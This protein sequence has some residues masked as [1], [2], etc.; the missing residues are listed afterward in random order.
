MQTHNLKFSKS[1]TCVYDCSRRDSQSSAGRQWINTC[2]IAPRNLFSW[3]K[4]YHHI[5]VY[6][7]R[8]ILVKHTGVYTCIHNVLF[9]V[10]CCLCNV[11]SEQAGGIFCSCF[12]HH[13]WV[14]TAVSVGARR[15]RACFGLSR[16]HHYTPCW[17]CPRE[18]WIWAIPRISVWNKNRVLFFVC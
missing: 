14:S 18:F 15:A 8:T 7:T 10:G 1:N 5:G 17:S 2:S 3:K 11:M 9:S 16:F 6:D 12:L 13:Q 4:I